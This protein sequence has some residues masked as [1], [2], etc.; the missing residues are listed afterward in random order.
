MS[1]RRSKPSPKSDPAESLAGLERPKP[2]W[3]LIAQITF[4]LAALW[5]V[6]AMAVQYIGQWGLVAMG[7]LTLIAIGF[8][9]Y[10]WRMTRKSAAIIDILQGATDKEGRAAAIEELRT[11]KAK[12]SDE[13]LNALA[14]AQL[15][16]Q[17][18][19]TEAVRIL[20]DIDLNKAPAMVQD[21]V[22]ANL[23]LLYLTQS[24]ARDARELADEIRIDRA[25]QAKSKAMYA[26]VVA[27]AYSRTGKAAEARKLIETYDA[28]DSE[29]EEVKPILLRAQVYTFFATKNRGLAK[30]AME[31]LIAID[32]NMVA[33]F[34]QKGSRPE[35]RQMATQVLAASGAL[36]KQQIRMR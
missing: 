5:V 23:A 12:G 24:R 34:M 13:A 14:E 4:G 35:L 25:P 36:P 29:Y 31:G 21:D 30:K 9:I 1:K 8:G 27:E 26:A 10:A 32:P 6:A 33:A 7:V 22:R 16:A 2:R 11:R 17:E 3:A 15:V 20:E 18:N 19:P 28:N